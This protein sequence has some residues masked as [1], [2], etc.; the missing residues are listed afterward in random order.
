MHPVAAPGL[1]DCQHWT[2]PGGT[3]DAATRNN[4]PFPA[5]TLWTLRRR[6]VRSRGASPFAL[7]KWLF[8]AI[9][10][11]RT[12]P[13]G[14]VYRRMSAAAI[15]ANWRQADGVGPVS[16]LG[17]THSVSAEARRRTHCRDSACA[18]SDRVLVRMD[19]P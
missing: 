14:W 2:D 1:F 17:D 16:F 5:V 18:K 12:G 9:G 19:R 4:P 13:N 11:R 3:A 7:G 6:A 15:A 10:R 8:G